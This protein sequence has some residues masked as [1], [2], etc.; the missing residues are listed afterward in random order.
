MRLHMKSQPCLRS[1]LK[2]LQWLRSKSTRQRLLQALFLKAD[3]DLSLGGFVALLSLTILF[4][5]PFFS[6]GQL[7]PEYLFHLFLSLI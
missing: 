4:F 2:S 3:G 6:S 5:S 7:L 1:T